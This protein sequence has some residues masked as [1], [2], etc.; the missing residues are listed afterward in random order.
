MLL[1]HEKVK[2][3]VVIPNWNGVSLLRDCLPTLKKQ[4]LKDFEI[5]VVDNGSTDQSVEFIKKNYPEV[6]L[7]TLDHN[8]GFAPAVNLG[9][10]KSKASFVLLLNNDTKVDS[11]CLEYLYNA[12]IAHKDVGMV[13]AKMLQMN[14]PKKIDSAGDYIDSVGHANNIGL[15]KNDGPE[16]ERPGYV[17]LVTGGGGLFKKT[18]FEKVGLLDEDYFAYFEDVDLCLRAQMVG[19]KGWFEPKAKIYHLH[20]ATSNKNKSFTEYLQFRNM[21]QTIIKDFPDKLLKK[22]FNWLKIFLVNINTVRYLATQGYLKEALRA[23]MYIVINFFR[24]LQKR[25][26]IQNKKIVD[27]NYLVGNFEPKKVTFFGLFKRGI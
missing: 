6:I 24:L 21:T 19:F 25:K 3:S 9:I 22:D 16:F 20:K 11:R 23:E 13:A 7:V 26:K 10:K 18:V 12:A 15:G 1:K 8:T 4:T 17:F 2:V 5:I 14:N 27:D